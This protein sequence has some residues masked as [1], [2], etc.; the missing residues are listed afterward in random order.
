MRPVICL[1]ISQVL[2]LKLPKKQKIGVLS[3]FGLGFLVVITSSMLIHLSQSQLSLTR[4]TVIRA[5]Y[6]YRNEQMI[7]CTVSMIE[8][9]IAIIA[10]C[11]PVMRTLFFGSRSRTG[12]YSGRRGYELSSSG[13]IGAGTK[14]KATVSASH[15]GSRSKTQLSRHDS[16]DELVRESASPAV[17]A[18]HGISVT[19]EYFI[20]EGTRDSQSLR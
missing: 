3:I 8:T 10:S 17:D 7:T 15:V 12:T 20:H 13:H 18:H 4:S 2:K 1:P 14:Q 11:L 6:S 5:V 16:E 9:A 19:R